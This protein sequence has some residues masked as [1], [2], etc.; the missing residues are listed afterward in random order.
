LAMIFQT[1]DEDE[2]HAWNNSTRSWEELDNS[3]RNP[4]RKGLRIANKLATVDLMEL[5]LQP[6]TEV[7]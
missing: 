2:T 6:A 3:Y 1:A 4:T 5:P 7:N